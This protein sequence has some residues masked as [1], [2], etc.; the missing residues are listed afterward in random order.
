MLIWI[1]KSV[2]L[3][4]FSTNLKAAQGIA[5]IFSSEFRGEHYVLSD[6]NTLRSLYSNQ[7]LSLA[8]RASVSAILSK[9]STVGSIKDIVRTRACVTY[10]R[11][12]SIVRSSP[13]EWE[14]PLLIIAEQG[15]KKAA[16][17]TENIDDAE[18]YEHAAKH[19]IA[20][21]GFGGRVVFERMPGGG[22]TIP[23]VFENSA[24]IEGRWCLCITDSDRV[25]PA[26]SMSSTATKCHKISESTTNIALHEVLA[27][28]EIE[29]ILPITFINEV[30][31]LTYRDAWHWHVENLLRLQPDAHDYCDLKSGTT[32]KFICSL[33]KKN[34]QRLEYWTK[35]V[36]VL[37]KASTLPSADCDE[38][39]VCLD[40]D[41]NCKCTITPGY[42]DHLLNGVLAFLEKVSPHD[43]HRR[44]QNDLKK[45]KWL[46][47]GRKV[48][49]WGCAPDRTRA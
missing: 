32:R 49:E 36:S 48:F 43:A 30:I 35:V 41:E 16:L 45:E 11:S 13:T 14:I 29:N 47:I 37:T 1:D 24:S 23:G 4:N 15:T 2:L 20:S 3:A 44:I 17:I 46:T 9:I 33:D 12:R 39:Y 18:A 19:Y 26:D 34:T 8:T 25:C 5:D 22:S 10:G 38:N 31:P 6:R 42:G 40:R 21:I 27:E 7:S 28:R